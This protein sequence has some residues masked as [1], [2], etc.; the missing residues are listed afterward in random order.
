MDVVIETTHVVGTIVR[1]VKPWSQR[2]DD[3]VV[4][5]PTHLRDTSDS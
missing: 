1:D 5:T 4:P 3:T 2:L